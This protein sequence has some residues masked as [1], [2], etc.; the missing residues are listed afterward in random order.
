MEFRKW[1]RKDFEKMIKL[2]EKMWK[3]G[4]YKKI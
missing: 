2:G 4:A 3:E 1:Q